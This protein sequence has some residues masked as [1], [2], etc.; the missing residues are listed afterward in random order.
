MRAIGI[1]TG[2]SL[3]LRFGNPYP[4]DFVQSLL[5][6]SMWLVPAHVA[7]ARQKRDEAHLGGHHF[8]L[9][10]AFFEA[11]AILLLAFLLE[12]DFLLDL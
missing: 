3:S 9:R 4:Y 5:L 7:T 12:G 1:R 11:L 2:A 8:F 6:E 10:F